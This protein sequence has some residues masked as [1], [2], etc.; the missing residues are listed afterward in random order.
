MLDHQTAADRRKEWSVRRRLLHRINDWV[1]RS[2]IADY[3]LGACV[4]A[5]YFATLYGVRLHEENSA[6]IAAEARRAEIAR[7]YNCQRVR[8]AG[9]SAVD[10]EAVNCVRVTGH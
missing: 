5:L 10:V 6:L 3:L 1:H 4:V 2:R 9:R 8:A 7:Q